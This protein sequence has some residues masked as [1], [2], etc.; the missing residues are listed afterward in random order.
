V[1][2]EFGISGH[3]HRNAIDYVLQKDGLREERRGRGSPAI[4]NTGK[5]VSLRFTGIFSDTP[6]NASFAVVVSTA[7]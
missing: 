5:K 2:L 7:K 3:A 4:R 1:H 6:T